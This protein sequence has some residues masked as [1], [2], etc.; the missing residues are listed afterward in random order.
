MSVV[1]ERSWGET[2]ANEFRFWDSFSGRAA[3]QRI[4]QDKSPADLRIS[5]NEFFTGFQ[6][7]TCLAN[8]GFLH[9]S[10]DMFH[11]FASEGVIPNSLRHLPMCWYAQLM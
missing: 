7:F 11:M 10:L 5:K 3:M 6:D 1:Y 2:T 9:L 8:G 4:M